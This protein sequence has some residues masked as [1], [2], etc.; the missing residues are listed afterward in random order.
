MAIGSTAT[1]YGSSDNL[2]GSPG[3]LKHQGSNEVKRAVEGSKGDREG[4]RWSW[5]SRGLL[6]DPIGPSGL[7]DGFP[8]HS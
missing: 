1:F 7:F 8:V 3:D 5:A 2:L 4:A 6:R